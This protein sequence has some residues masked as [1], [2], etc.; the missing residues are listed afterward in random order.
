MH[1]LLATGFA[2]EYE[3][4]L[5]GGRTS[6][7]NLDG[8][9][10]SRSLTACWRV[11]FEEPMLA[12]LARF[13]PA[14]AS[15]VLRIGEMTGSIMTSGDSVSGSESRIVTVSCSAMMDDQS[16]MAIFWLDALWVAR[17]YKALDGERIEADETDDERDDSEDRSDMSETG[18]SGGEIGF[19]IDGKTDPKASPTLACRA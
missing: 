5:A 10:R 8:G 18:V 7:R 16:S 1:G 11:G 4:I 6:G 12:P 17:R 19:R 3:G 2:P 14:T 9:W 13:L 15:S